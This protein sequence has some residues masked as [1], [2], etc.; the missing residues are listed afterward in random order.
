M[1][2]QLDLFRDPAPEAL[3]RLEGDCASL[4]ALSAMGKRLPAGL[5]LGAASWTPAVH[6]GAV[7]PRLPAD[8][9][10]P[11]T[12]LEAYATHPLV[13]T[14]GIDRT[15]YAPIAEGAFRDLAQRVPAEFRFVVKA[16]QS[17]TAAYLFETRERSAH[18]LDPRAAIDLFVAPC[19]AGLGA[20]GRRRRGSV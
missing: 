11:G 13:R 20:A 16:P 2:P 10:S 6:E 3:A 15:F 9:A 14:V 7:D 17:L 12:G 19:L 18:F 5:R 4:P 8:R 1:N